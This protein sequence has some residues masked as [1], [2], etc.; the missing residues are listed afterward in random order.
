[1]Q[2]NKVY[3]SIF[4]LEEQGEGELL[5]LKIAP[6]APETMPGRNWFT[7][8]PKRSSTEIDCTIIKEGCLIK[9]PPSYLFIKRASWKGRFFKLCKTAVGSYFI[10]Y[11]AYD[12]VSMD[13]KG[14][15]PVCDIKSIELGTNA[16]DKNMTTITNL[17][18]N[19]PR[20]VL[21]IKTNKRVFY[22]LDE[23]EENIKNW[24][25]CIT[26]VWVKINQTENV[27]GPQIRHTVLV[28]PPPELPQ[29]RWPR[30]FRSLAVYPVQTRQA[31][32]QFVRS[33]IYQKQ[34]VVM[35]ETTRPKSY[36]VDHPYSCPPVLD[37]RQ[38]SY[39]DPNSRKEIPDCKPLNLL[40][41]LPKLTVERK[42]S[43]TCTEARIPL[44]NEFRRLSLSE[45]Q[46]TSSVDTAY[47]SD[48]EIY[49]VPRPGLNRIS[50]D[51]TEEEE[52]ER[53]DSPDENVYMCMDQ[54]PSPQD[55]FE[56]SETNIGDSTGQT[57]NPVDEQKS[58]SEEQNNHC[59]PKPPRNSR[60][61]EPD[62]SPKPQ[63]SQLKRAYI[64]KMVFEHDSSEYVKMY[65]TIPTAHLRNYFDLQ[66]VG[67]RLCVSKWKGPVEIG[68]VFH[69]GDHINE[70]N[71]FRPESKDFFFQML[72]LFTRDEVNLVVTRNMKAG[73]FHLEGCNCGTS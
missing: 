5:L 73:V 64:L 46:E 25:K 2:A 17:F 54:I 37:D 38:R 33:E 57:Q 42:R 61:I 36:P 35:D 15:I 44:K 49:D 21:C 24:Q 31:A 1:M 66:E 27:D 20:N 52:E 28:S 56:D 65:L 62:R 13:Y 60:T 63:G 4:R 10:R 47:Y 45:Q 51:S 67:E 12:G 40:M 8:P 26:D 58:C 50:Q 48:T 32:V 14:E 39:T 71:G 59:P 68:C 9:S 55:S 30:E 70:I 3:G 18:N 34:A 22:L 43:H 7:M 69:H 41:T 29:P 16:M 53:F 23:N 11:Y 72:N 6:A 19:S